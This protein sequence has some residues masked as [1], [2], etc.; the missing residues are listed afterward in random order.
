M[1][2]FDATIEAADRSHCNT[3]WRA[4]VERGACDATR[5]AGGDEPP[6]STRSES[7]YFIQAGGETGPIKIGNSSNVDKRMDSLRTGNHLP[8]TLLGAF[9][10]HRA[11]TVERELH[12][13][14]DDLR[15]E[16]EWFAFSTRIMDIIDAFAGE[17]SIDAP[18]C[19]VDPRSWVVEWSD[20]QG[21]IHVQ[22]L[23]EHLTASRFALLH[24]RLPNDYTLVGILDTRD[25]AHAFA[26]DIEPK[27]RAR[28]LVCKL[29]GDKK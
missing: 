21:F 12:A 23:A 1:N 6:A 26:R 19:S 8:L 22:T 2:R 3:C 4:G 24:G 18:G 27:L 15:L 13:A 17:A 20:R 28:R 14:L 10:C 5:P 25:E 29:L 9:P 11:A 7:V 16:G